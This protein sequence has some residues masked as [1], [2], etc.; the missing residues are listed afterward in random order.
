LSEG[1]SITGLEAMLV[2]APV[3]SSNATCLPEVYGDAVWYFNPLDVYDMAS[4]INEVLTNP[5]LRNKLIRAGREQV[6]KYSWQHMA[7]QT[8]SVYEAVLSK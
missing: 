8:L 2:R 4:S 6:K 5:E 1:F 7:E 3:V